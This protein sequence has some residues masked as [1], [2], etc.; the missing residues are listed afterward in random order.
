MNRA[1]SPVWGVVIMVVITI[2]LASMFAVA[3][4]GLYDLDVPERQ[5]DELVSGGHV[6]PGGNAS[7]GG[8]TTSPW[9]LPQDTVVFTDEQGHLYSY[10]DGNVTAYRPP[11]AD[12]DWQVAAIGPK[13]LNFDDDARK[14]VPFVNEEND[15]KLIDSTNETQVLVRD[16]AAMTFLAVG[17]WGSEELDL[18]RESAVYYIDDHTQAIYRVAPGQEPQ[19]VWD[20]DE[21]DDDDGG[22][23]NIKALVGVADFN[24][25]GD[26]DILYVNNQEKL[27]YV[28]G[29]TA[30]V[31]DYDGI[32]SSTSY[33]YGVG[34]PV[35]LDGDGTPRVPVVT[36]HK[37]V[38]L[39]GRGGNVTDLGSNEEAA[40]VPVTAVEAPGNYWGVVYVSKG[41]VLY[42]V[43]ASGE[44]HKLLGPNGDPITADADQGVA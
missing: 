39:L 32:G 25:D 10:H 35:D 6:G 33:G 7:D 2:L 37:N 30:N 11:A 9:A 13:K 16:G 42:H 14:E 23:T 43:T 18:A 29:G 19:A 34:Q 5:A 36:G 44:R 8:G 21:G 4:P 28:D 38:V 24:G 3:L 15:L 1:I 22:S 41:E 40:P 26:T 12:S 20:G 17:T 27:T 31:V